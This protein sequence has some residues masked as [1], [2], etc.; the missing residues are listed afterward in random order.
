MLLRAPPRHPDAELEYPI[1]ADPSLPLPDGSNELSNRMSTLDAAIA[2]NAVSAAT[3]GA[4][5]AGNGANAANNASVGLLPSS[6]IGV[7]LAAERVALLAWLRDS[8]TPAG[9]CS[10]W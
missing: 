6:G 4:P 9:R 5:S 10:C 1:Y 3:G 8:F 7:L 2:R